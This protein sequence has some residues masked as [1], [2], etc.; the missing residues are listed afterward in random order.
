MILPVKY[1]FLSEQLLSLHMFYVDIVTPVLT[2]FTM[3]H[4]KSAVDHTRENV[5]GVQR[6]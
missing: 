6:D 1:T 3:C 4:L 5:F 2:V